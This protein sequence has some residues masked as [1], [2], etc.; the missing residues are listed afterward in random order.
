MEPPKENHK[1]GDKKKK[2]EEIMV[3]RFPNLMKNLKLYLLSSRNMS[4]KLRQQ[5]AHS[6]P[7]CLKSWKYWKHFKVFLPT[8]RN[9]TRMSPLIPST[10]LILEVLN[11]T[12]K[13]TRRM[14]PYWKERMKSVFMLRSHDYL[15]RKWN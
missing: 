8:I 6:K 3:I 4:K 12:R 15:C 2:I 7:T 5:I 14:H 11:W 13:Q 1:S 9:R 10:E